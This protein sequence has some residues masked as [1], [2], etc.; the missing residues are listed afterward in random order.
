MPSFRLLST[1]GL[2]LG[3]L[4]SQALTSPVSL[5]R[6]SSPGGQTVVYW[7]QNGGGTE[8]NNDLSAY[9]TASQGI[10]I[11]VLS[12]LYQ[13]GNGVTVPGGSFG[14]SCTVLATSGESQ[15]CDSVV[16]SITTCQEAGIKV[17]L[18]LGGGNGGYTV[19]SQSEAEAIGQYLWDAYGNS[20]TST[21]T[22]PFG[23]VIVNGFDF[24]IENNS[25]GNNQY[26][27]YMISTLRSNFAT[28]TA[29]TYYI[30]G[31]PQCP[32]PE[33][34]MGEIIGNST[35]DYIWPQFYNNNNYTY[36]CALGINGDAA[37]NFDDW[38]T[39][40]ADTPSSGAQLFIGVPAAPLAANGGTAGE[41]YYATPSQLAT[42]VSSVDSYSQFG[43]IMLWSAGFS[44]SNVIDGCTFA[45]EADSILLT[46]SPCSSGGFTLTPSLTPVAPTP[47]FSTSTGTSSP[48]GT[49]TPVPEYGQC[50][51]DGYTGSTACQ[52][53]YVCVKQ[54]DYWSSCQAA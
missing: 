42:I 30:S 33:P 36:P 32:L 13:F 17:L 18:S 43:G 39:F 10:D 44:D 16:S 20:A 11:I 53:P 4:A 6:R 41:V 14:Q 8:E 25:N 28:D 12:F 51:G 37:F 26:Y 29:N 1:L 34:N 23:D 15:N 5:P 54:S 2:G 50:G 46:G 19:T 35:F 31:A 40:I 9:C 48:T 22:R 24:D 38:E 27:K 47:A 3:F 7:G 52:S 49:G 21:V 45:Q